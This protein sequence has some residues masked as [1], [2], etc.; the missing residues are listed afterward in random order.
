LHDP[1]AV[2]LAIDKSLATEMT[3]MHIDVE[4]KGELT[5]GETVA[6]RSLY[7]ETV[8]RVA[9]RNRLV[10]FPRVEPNADVPVVVDHERFRE[11]F[12]ERLIAER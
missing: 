9:E 7:L 11:M 6:N 2:G 12:F 1:L 5:V 4:T 3:P 8:E 10:S